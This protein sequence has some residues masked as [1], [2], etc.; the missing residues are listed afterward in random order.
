MSGFSRGFP[1]RGSQNGN[2]LYK[3]SPTHCLPEGQETNSVLPPR[4]LFEAM[5]GGVPVPVGRRQRLPG[6]VH[7][8][9][10]LSGHSTWTDR[11]CF[12]SASLELVVWSLVLQIGCLEPGGLVE[13]V[14]NLYKNQVQIPTPIRNSN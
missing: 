3:K 2:Q 6:F 8:Q 5:P 13:M 11:R 14:P 4:P 7:G 10:S 9:G 12:E 1:F